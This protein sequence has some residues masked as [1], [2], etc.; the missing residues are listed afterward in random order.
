MKVP[1][2]TLRLAFALIAVA[3]APAA[4][5]HAKQALFD[6]TKTITVTGSITRVEWTNPHSYI[7]IDVKGAGGEVQH[8]LFELAGTTVLQH[9]GL[10]TA[11]RGLRPGEVLTVEAFA[12]RD[13]GP[14]G[15]VS[16]LRLADGRVVVPAYATSR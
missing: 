3:A 16:R 8:W 9:A 11:D 12:A 7:S 1:G 10:T 2:R 14:V 6:L 4:A 15:F 5:H 13:G